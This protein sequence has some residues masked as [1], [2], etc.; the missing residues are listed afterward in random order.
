[1]SKKIPLLCTYLRNE[2]TLNNLSWRYAK[3]NSNVVYVNWAPQEP[4]NNGG[5]GHCVTIGVYQN[6][7]W[8]DDNCAVKHVYI[9]ETS[10][11]Y[12]N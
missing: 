1:M 2:L 12:V 5:H 6:E 11:R 10:P 9:C 4:N 8:D 7:L 3:D